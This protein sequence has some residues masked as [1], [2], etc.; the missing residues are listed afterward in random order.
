MC[1][2][3]IA[4]MAIGTGISAF[5]QY[6]AGKAAKAQANYA[7]QVAKNN[8]IIQEQNAKAA[9]DKAS[10][11]KED[12]RRETLQRIGLQRAQLAAQG[13]DVGDGSALDILGDTAALGELDVLRIEADGENRARNFRVQASNYTA[14]SDLQIMKGKSASSAGKIGAFST[15][16]GGAGRIGAYMES[17]S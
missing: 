4:L 16:L 14:E 12:R 17:T 8:A 13:F 11:D 5:G 3:T 7:S 15:L 2:P 1:S 6:Q 9:L 10:A